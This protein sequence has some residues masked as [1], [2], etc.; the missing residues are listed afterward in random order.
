MAR[1]RKLTPA[2]GAEILAR[3]RAGVRRADIA[4]EAGIGY[5]TLAEWLE[6]GR[7]GKAGFRDFAHAFD[8]AQALVYADR[9]HERRR[10]PWRT[11]E[12]REAARRRE[13]LWKH[14]ES[15]PDPSG[16]AGVPWDDD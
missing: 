9:R 3:V 10:C 2:L 6:R 8:A 14:L 13:R 15:L 1:P 7:S 11:R 4:D 12:A 16:W 5:R